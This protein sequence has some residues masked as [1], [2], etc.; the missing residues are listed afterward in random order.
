MYS[1]IKPIRKERDELS[2]DNDNLDDNLSATTSTKHQQQQLYH[3]RE[4]S[5]ELARISALVTR[6]P[7]QKTPTLSTFLLKKY[8]LYLIESRDKNKSDSKR[9]KFLKSEI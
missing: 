4:P 2:A 5:P 6:P 1:T 9:L 8:F 3:H 7:K